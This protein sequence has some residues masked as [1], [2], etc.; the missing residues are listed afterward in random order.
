MGSHRIIILA[1]IL[2]A[3]LMPFNL[4][5]LPTLHAVPGEKNIIVNPSFEDS[6]CPAWTSTGTIGGGT[7]KLCDP[8]KA[9][10]GSH[11]TVLNAT[12]PA[13]GT[14]SSKDAVR[15]VVRQDF[16]IDSNS[17]G[18]DSLG[19]L[20][21]SFSMWWYVDSPAQF[22]MLGLYSIH[23]SISFYDTASATQ[24]SIE[25]WYG[26]SDLANVTGGHSLAYRVGDLQTGSWFQTVRNITAD[27]QGLNIV[28]PAVTKMYYS[29][30]GAF[31]NT[32]Y[33]E[34]VYLDDIALNTL[35][36]PVPLLSAN[37]LAGPS[38]LTVSFDGTGS[39]ES[40]VD[41]GVSITNYRWSF[42][43]GTLD[44][45]GASNGK[46]VHTYNNPGDYIVVL[47]VTDS[48]GQSRSISSKIS[49]SVGEYWVGPLVAGALAVVLVAGWLLF[50]RPHGRRA[51]IRDSNR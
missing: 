30:F 49:V 31:G 15:A 17:P 45:T 51:R 5:H 4:S 35:P 33:G 7:V 14:V 43:D 20:G 24:Y 23:F 21:D 40:S 3:S 8:S 50:R 34:N 27:I 2:V 46:V 29:W 26:V 18:V 16:P 19:S 13:P 44:V 41:S 28:N 9:L 1:F 48:N 32:T 36:H 22:G 47:T 42:G 38:P 6:S 11:S 37:P 10:T 25:Y 39:T 12:K